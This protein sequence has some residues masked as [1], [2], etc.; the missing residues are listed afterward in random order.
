MKMKTCLLSILF[1]MTFLVSG[2]AQTFTLKGGLNLSSRLV[3][4]KGKSEN[5]GL[6]L[7]PGFHVGGTLDFPVRERISVETGLLLSMKGYKYSGGGATGIESKVDLLFL[8]VPVNGRI[9]FN[10]GGVGMY[11]TFGPYFGYG[12]V[13]QNKYTDLNGN[14][15]TEKSKIVWGDKGEMRRFDAG[16]GVGVGILV[17]SMTFGINYDLGLLNQVPIDDDLKVKNSVLGVSVGYRF[18]KK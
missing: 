8:H 3:H 17:N 6:K 18:A 9:S 12:L 5:E 15:S 11:G 16:F 4:Y 14:S 2:F 13:G 1:I 10:L 7:N